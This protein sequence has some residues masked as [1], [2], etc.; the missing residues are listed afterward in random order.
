MEYK[1]I[2]SK[3]MLQTHKKDGIQRA[4]SKK[5]NYNKHN[6][7]LMSSMKGITKDHESIM[8]DIHSNSPV[9]AGSILRL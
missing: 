9:L 1:N 5:V 6:Q 4:M 3:F 7:F 8:K 2:S